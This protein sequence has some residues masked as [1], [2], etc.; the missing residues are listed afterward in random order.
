MQIYTNLSNTYRIWVS[1][2]IGII[3]GSIGCVVKIGWEVL[4][5][6]HVKLS[7]DSKTQHILQLFGS[8][9]HLLYLNYVFSDGY[10]WNVFYLAWQFLLS[11]ALSLLY[12]LCAEFW[13]KLKFAHGILYGIASWLLVYVLFLPLCGFITINTDSMLG[14]YVCS[15]IESLLW[16]W[17]I[18]LARRDLRN[19]ITQEQDP[20]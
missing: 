15:F 11:L 10:E 8:D 19:R 16:I 5:P 14:Y 6:L 12:V 7:L 4:F 13:Q 9:S 18:E 20:F 2:C 17:I 3:V 1:L